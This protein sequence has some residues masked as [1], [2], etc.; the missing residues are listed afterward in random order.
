MT[1]AQFRK[2]DEYEM[3]VFIHREGVFLCNYIYGNTV[4]DAYQVCS[5]YVTFSYA[6]NQQGKATINIF[7]DP[8]KLRFFNEIK[9]PDF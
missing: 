9:I 4:Y 7:N 5:F 8:E 1:L 6:L 3:E 2:L